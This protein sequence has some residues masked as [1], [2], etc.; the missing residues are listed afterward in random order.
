VGT[1]APDFALPDASGRKVSLSDYR[2][3]PTVVVFYPLDWSPGCSQQLD[4]YQ[5]ELDSFTRRGARLLAISVDS[6][7]SHGA[8]AAVRRIEFPLLADFHPKGEAAQRYDVYRD[9]DG[10]SERAVFVVDEQGVI[11]YAHVSPFLHHVPD[12]YELFAALDALPSAMR[13]PTG[14]AQ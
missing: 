6:I 9:E 5:E 14:V 1:S 13:E 12:I 11:R 8:W 10:F 2:G 3:H 7:Y 4:L